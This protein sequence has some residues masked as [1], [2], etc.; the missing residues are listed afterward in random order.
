M[1]WMSHYSIGYINSAINYII[2]SLLNGVADNVDDVQSGYLVDPNSQDP[3][4]S[5]LAKDHF[6]HHFHS[7]ASLLSQE[8][9]YRTGVA[10]IN[11]WNKKAEN[12]DPFKV[13]QS[14]MV[15]PEDS[16]WHN[17]ILN[18]WAKTHTKEIKRGSSRG[19]WLDFQKEYDQEIEQMLT[20]SYP[21]ADYVRKQFVH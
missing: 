2:S 20:V 6:E 15:H 4:H 7:I 13:V 5:Q 10:L 16:T 12:T 1:G 21:Y 17:E 3:T 14:L 18:K 9:V 11:A 8:A 19:W